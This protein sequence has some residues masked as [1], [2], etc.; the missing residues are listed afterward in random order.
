MHV[1]RTLITAA[2]LAAAVIAPQPAAATTQAAPSSVVA[3]AKGTVVHLYRTPASVVPYRAL[4]SPNT[5]GA[6]LVFLVKARRYGWELVYLP[7]RPNG[8][9]A[10]IRDREVTLTLD[11]YKVIVY[12]HAHL[13]VVLKE[14]RVIEREPA[15][16]GRSVVPTPM[17]TYYLVELLKQPDRW[18]LYGPYAFGLSAHSN[19]LYSFGGGPGQIGIHGTNEP[20]ALGSDVSHGCVRISNAAISR[21]AAILPLGTPVEIRP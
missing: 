10:W 8:S 16:V 21:L 3:Q 5:D 19:I 15:G 12:L 18:G 14:N 13:L 1:S 4:R 20:W 6:P 2:A 9:V 11:P 17:G 7:S